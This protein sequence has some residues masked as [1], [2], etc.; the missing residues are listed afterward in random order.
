[1][2]GTIG[3]NRGPNL[4]TASDRP[5]RNAID[6]QHLRDSFTVAYRSLHSRWSYPLP[7][8]D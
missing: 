3:R 2:S 8:S 5:L 7:G 4:M 1:M 6:E